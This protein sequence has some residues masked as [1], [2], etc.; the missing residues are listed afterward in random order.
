[1]KKIIKLTENDFIFDKVEIEACIIDTNDK[2][3]N[4]WLKNG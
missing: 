4:Q 3:D 2:L 1:M